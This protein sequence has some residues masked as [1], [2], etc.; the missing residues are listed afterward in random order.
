MKKFKSW[1]LASSEWQHR[2][3]TMT[4]VCGV[5]S[6]RA[7]KTPLTKEALFISIFRSHLTTLTSRLL[8]SSSPKFGIRTSHHKLALFA[9]TFSKMN[10]ALLWLSEPLS[11]LYKR[12]SV[13]L[14]QMIHKMPKW[15]DNIKMTSSNSIQQRNTG[16]RVLQWSPRGT[17]MRP[18]RGWWRWVSMNWSLKRL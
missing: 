16:H 14:S 11:C 17:R 2:C 6:F 13:L 15:Q 5:G 9:S 10:G 18:F 7:L 8:W 3:W 4:F 12:C 1:K